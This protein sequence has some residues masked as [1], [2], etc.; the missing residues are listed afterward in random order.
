MIGTVCE[1]VE[2]CGGNGT[3]FVKRVYSGS[4]VVIIVYVWN[5]HCIIII[6]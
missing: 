4:G 2:F 5:F 1:G 3:G 6:V